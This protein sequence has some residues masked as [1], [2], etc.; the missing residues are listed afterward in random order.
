MTGDG[1]QDNEEH[2]PDRRNL[3]AVLRAAGASVQ[4]L[5]A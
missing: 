1:G 2:Y 3:R 4:L 5:L